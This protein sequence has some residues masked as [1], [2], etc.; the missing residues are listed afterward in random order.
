LGSLITAQQTSQD[1]QKLSK[2]FFKRVILKFVGYKNTRAYWNARW[3]LG[4]EAE[5]WTQETLQHEFTLIAGL[6][7]QYA[8]QNVL[9]VGCGKAHLRNLKG[10]IGLDY[11]LEGLKKS[12]VNT[13]IYGDVSDRNLPIPN[14]SFDAVLT[15]FVLLHIPFEK[16]EFAVENI[17][18]IGKKLIILKEPTSAVPKQTH[19]HCFSYNFPKLF[20]RFDGKVVFLS[21]G[22]EAIVRSQIAPVNER[23]AGKKPET[24]EKPEI[25]I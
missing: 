20:E 4:L 14:Q 19:F 8:C 25:I 7:E 18:R 16:I 22:K 1:Q 11:S 3:K 24:R 5:K 9:E 23:V 13:F 2:D 21:S 10:H 15:R 6:M 12:E 17:C